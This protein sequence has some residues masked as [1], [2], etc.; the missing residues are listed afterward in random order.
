MSS[1]LLGVTE[2]APD[3]GNFPPEIQD[4]IRK[5]VEDPEK[6][7]ISA[8]EELARQ[9]LERA[10]ASV[11]YVTPA[12]K[13]SMRIIEKDKKENYLKCLL[14]ICTKLYQERKRT[15]NTT[16]Y[17]ASP[18]PRFSAFR[19]FLQQLYCQVKEKKSSYKLKYQGMTPM[20]AILIILY[21]SCWDCLIPPI[22]EGKMDS[23]S[24]AM[25][26][27]GPDLENGLPDR[28]PKLMEKIRDAFLQTATIPSVKKSLLHIIELHASKWKLSSEAVTYYDTN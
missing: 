19:Q 23:L 5:A 11:C 22:S 25:T 8:H 13:L 28:F 2:E 7:P 3:L 27:T 24:F 17:S 16:P 4:I 20:K 9:V 1:G 12:V 15:L 6:L 26:S 14:Q 10:V 21:S 18:C